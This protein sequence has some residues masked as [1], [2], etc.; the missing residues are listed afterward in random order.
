MSTKT[1]TT[2]TTTQSSVPNMQRRA[3][4]KTGRVPKQ[5]KQQIV[6][7]VAGPQPRL[8]DGFPVVPTTIRTK[9]IAQ[10]GV[11]GTTAKHLADTVRGLVMPYTN[12]SS[13]TPI[14]V[15]QALAGTSETYAATLHER[16]DATFSATQQPILAYAFRSI[17]RAFVHT[18]YLNEGD[19]VL[20]S[21]Q[22]TGASNASRISNGST[23]VLN[24][25]C[26]NRVQASATPVSFAPH[27]QRL[28]PGRLGPS[29]PKRGWWMDLSC[30]MA[31]TFDPVTLSSSNYTLL[32]YTLQGKTWSIIRESPITSASPT[33]NFIIA[34]DAPSY[35]SFELR[36][37]DPPP[38]GP[39]GYHN[40]AYTMSLQIGRGAST[41]QHTTWCHRHTPGLAGNLADLTGARVLS[42]SAMI[43]NR[44]ANIQ[45]GGQVIG[46]P[47]PS[48]EA[49]TKYDF[50]TISK[51]QLS[52]SE[53][54]Q[55]G[56]YGFLR[57][58]GLES[59]DPVFETVPADYTD[60]P[61]AGI[62]EL[63]D[64]AFNI[65]NQ[66]PSLAI[67]FLYPGTSQ[68]AVFTFA[69]NIEA[70]SNN[71]L[72]PAMPCMLREAEV[73]HAINFASKIPQFYTNEDHEVS[74]FEKIWNGVKS[75]ATDA[76]NAIVT[77]GPAV[78][79][80]AKYLLPMLV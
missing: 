14:R 40:I 18:A 52:F 46:A 68:S 69:Q 47:I 78:M 26:L 45:L 13:T 5:R 79:D 1:T 17:L 22:V 16:L 70:F 51:S 34:P 42:A 24:P 35:F 48:N 39:I 65:F 4:P 74:I 10:E 75:F 77:Y 31:I 28:F 32:V 60:L 50:D 73:R 21:A 6:V 20:Y 3:R 36:D 59:F 61:L 72:F 44:A 57:P 12:G 33:Y 55:K 19:T 71:P 63:T 53:S 56:V 23:L 9:R 15:A 54:A 8:H 66:H 58:S 25:G 11:R 80:A 43:T 49:W 38:A 2:K 41:P 62:P 29:D 64:A 76:A 67:S 30:G 27:G 7:Q 37:N